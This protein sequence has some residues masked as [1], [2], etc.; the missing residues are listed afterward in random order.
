MADPDVTLMLEELQGTHA[1]TKNHYALVREGDYSKFIK[2]D[3]K[4]SYSIK[5]LEYP[6]TD[7]H[8]EL[9]SSLKELLVRVNDYRS[10]HTF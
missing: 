4:A 3:W 1:N 6:R 2:A 10:I 5:A 9:L 7:D 8:S